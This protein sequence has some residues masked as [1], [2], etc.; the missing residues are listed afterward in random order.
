MRWNVLRDR[1]V[2][3]CC[4]LLAP[5][6][7]WAGSLNPNDFPL[8]VHIFSHNSHSHYYHLT[9]DYVDGEGRANLYENGAPRAFDYNYRCGDRLINSISYETYLARWKK[10]GRTLEILL[11]AMGKPDSQNTCEV[12][13]DMKE[14]MAYYRHNGLIEEETSAA[15]KEWMQRHDYDPEHGKNLPV[16][17]SPVQGEGPAANQT[18]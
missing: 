16:N 3:A 17:L 1:R 18:P 8:R 14:S 6:A 5:F 13:V 10:P 15:F 2:F 9:L 12:K 7:A 4:F 11:P